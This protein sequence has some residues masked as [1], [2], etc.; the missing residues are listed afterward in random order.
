MTT[1]FVQSQTPTQRKCEKAAQLP[2]P[3]QSA[4]WNDSTSRNCRLIIIAWITQLLHLCNTSAFKK[5]EDGHSQTWREHRA[6]VPQTVCVGD[7]SKADLDSSLC[8]TPAQWQMA[9]EGTQ[10]MGTISCPALALLLATGLIT[11]TLLTLTLDPSTLDLLNPCQWKRQ[12]Y[13]SC[14]ARAAQST[15]TEFPASSIHWAKHLDIHVALRG[16]DRIHIKPNGMPHALCI[17][18]KWQEISSCKMV[19][20]AF[21]ERTVDAKGWNQHPYSPSVSVG[22]PVT[23]M[24]FWDMVMTRWRGI[25]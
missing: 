7:N 10:G 25:G 8:S 15:V 2:A 22:F 5:N 3:P 20:F 21:F 19:L 6:S 13:G 12:W 14:A 23:I 17:F 16:L 4:T 18:W 11:A 9:E 1:T 24:W